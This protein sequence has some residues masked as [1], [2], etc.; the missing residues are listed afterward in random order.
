M[1]ESLPVPPGDPEPAPQ[2]EE[3]PKRGKLKIFF[4]A[5]PGVGKTFAML[6]AAKRMLDSGSDVVIGLVDTHDDADSEGMLKHF[7]VVPPALVKGSSRPGELDLDRVLKR[8]PDVVVIDNLAHANYEGAR[9]PHRWNDVDE[10]LGNGI[11]VYTAMIVQELDSLADVVGEITGI[12]VGR[13]TV[14]D[15]FFDSAE[16]TVIV[17]MSADELLARLRAGKVLSPEAKEAS[18]SKFFRKGNLL[19]LREIALR[20]TADVV[21]DEVQKYRAEQ[22]IGAVWKTQGHLLCCIGPTPGA[23]HVVRSAARLANQLDV[24]W[25]AAYVETPKLQ[26]LPAEERGRILQVVSLAEEL[27]ARTAILTGN[28]AAA[29]IVDYARVE[30]ISTIL[31]GRSALPRFHVMRSLSERLAAESDDID[32]IEI[33]AAGKETGPKLAQLALAVEARDPRA[34]EKRLRYVWTA[35]IAILATSIAM[36]L[37]RYFEPANLVMVYFLAVILIAVRWGRGP[38]IFAAILNVLAFDFFFVPPLY[39]LMVADAEYLFTFAVMLA[40]GVITGQLAGNLRFQARVAFHRERRARTLYEFARDLS[41]KRTTAQVIE[42]TEQFMSRQFRGRIAVLVPDAT[43]M[44][45]SPTGRGMTNPFDATTAQWAYDQAKAAGAGTDTMAS[46]E[47]LFLPL[48]SPTRTRGVLAIRP[49][50][51]RDLMIPEQRHQFDIFAALVATALERVHYVDVARDALLMARIQSKDLAL[52]LHAKSIPELAEA[53]IRSLGGALAKHSVSL[54]IPRD[55]PMVSVDPKL[56][57]RVFLSL[58]GNVAKHTPAGTHATVSARLAGDYVEVSVADDGPGLP[59]GREER[60]F[61]SFTRGDDTP[62]PRQGAGLG[63]AIV[64]AIVEAHGGSIHAEKARETGAR[65]IFTLPL[66]R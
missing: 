53:G 29:A 24:P 50:R 25:T 27:G 63:L 51:A 21:E 58:V 49:E 33:G 7:E 35:G 43:G 66:K 14:P 23:E 34:G 57:E 60:I 6:V 1:A 16:E 20:R 65:I 40:V 36:V 39:S 13:E 31:L 26:R 46:N 4:G 32:L 41:T 37:H 47:H 22:A 9:H 64:R 55:L 44:L 15:T 54:E 8:D 19:A 3:T 30:N 62:S 42:T 12:E 59:P 28:D 17:D 61:E 2:G 18:A 38:A 10:I 56:M 11:D 45:V 5:F 48:K 52:D